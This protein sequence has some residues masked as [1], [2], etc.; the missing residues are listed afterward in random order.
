MYRESSA[1]ENKCYNFIIEMAKTNRPF[2]KNGGNFR[3]THAVVELL[4]PGDGEEL[5]HVD[6]VVEEEADKVDAVALQG[7][8]RRLLQRAGRPLLT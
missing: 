8:L 7:L 6:A 5:V 2:C 4:Q 3:K 1:T